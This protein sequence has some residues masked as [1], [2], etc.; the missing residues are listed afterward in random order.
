MLHAPVQVHLSAEVIR[1]LRVGRLQQLDAHQP[2]GAAKTARLGDANLSEAAATCSR[3]ARRSERRATRNGAPAAGERALQTSATRPQALQQGSAVFTFCAN[4]WE[5]RQ[6]GAEGGL[7]DCVWLP[8][9]IGLKAGS[10]HAYIHVVQGGQRSPRTLRKRKL[11][12]H[13]KRK[14]GKGEHA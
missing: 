3:S 1:Q 13:I 7:L 14:K 6:N 9:G 10:I 5:R 2:L 4:V 11:A 8:P 12:F